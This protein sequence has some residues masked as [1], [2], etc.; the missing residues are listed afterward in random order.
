MESYSH[1]Y[2]S[3]TDQSVVYFPRAKTNKEKN[4]IISI[5]ASQNN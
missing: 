5:Y 2:D 1:Y 3:H 4:P